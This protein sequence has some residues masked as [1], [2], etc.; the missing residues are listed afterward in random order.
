MTDVRALF[1]GR[2]N[3]NIFIVAA[4]IN[5]FALKLLTLSIATKTTAFAQTKAAGAISTR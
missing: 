3:M 2:I 5:A 4:A 1:I